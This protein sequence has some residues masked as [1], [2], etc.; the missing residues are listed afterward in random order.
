MSGVGPQLPTVLESTLARWLLGLDG[1]TNGLPAGTTGVSLV[2]EHPM[3]GWAWFLALLCI[4]AF[5]AW[6]YFGLQGSKIVRVVLG[7]FRFVLLVLILIAAT[8]PSLRF[9]REEVERDHVILLIDRSRSIDIAD[10]TAGE[11]RDVVLT[12]AL[13]D[14]KPMFELISQSK[15]ID[16]LGFG[17]TTFPL[18]DGKTDT[19]AFAQPIL[20]PA[21][22]DETRLDLALTQAITR[23]G[24]RPLSAVVILSDGRSAAPVSRET[25]TALR[26]RGIKIFVMPLG[27]KDPIGDASILSAVAPPT[28]FVRDRVPVRVEIDRGAY[29]GTLRAVL[30]DAKSGVALDTQEVRDGV[31][32]IMLDAVSDVPA[33]VQ[34]RVE[35]RGDPPDLVAENNERTLRLSF[36]DQPIRVLFLDGSARWEFRYFKNLLLREDSIEASTMLLSADHDFAQEGN[37]ALARLP[38]TKEE[39]AAY[40]LFVLGDVPS[41]FFAPE[42]LEMIR[43]QVAERGS[44]LLWIG[45][46]RDTPTSWEGTALADLLPFRAPFNLTS[47]RDLRVE[48]TLAARALGLL[49]L[50]PDEDGEGRDGDGWP[51]AF[52]P[53]AS[54]W[55]VLRW[56]QIIPATQ[57]KPT[58]EILAVGIPAF[59][60]TP[61][62]L[63]TPIVLRMRFGAG[64]T[65]YVATDEIWRWRYGQG[66]R[67]HERFWIPIVRMLAREALMSGS[68]NVLLRV[69]PRRATLG[70]RVSVRLELRDQALTDALAGSIPIE[71]RDA[72]GEVVAVIDALRDGSH[73]HAHW[74]AD[75]VG[76]Y[77]AVAADPALDK[78]TAAFEVIRR[79]DE[80]R[81]STPDHQ[82]LV[83]LAEA[84]NGAVLTPTTLRDLAPLLPLRAVTTDA[85]VFERLWDTPLFLILLLLLPTLE[86]TGRRILR[87]A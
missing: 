71:I 60:A 51:N 7:S 30:V 31:T 19:G 25:L 46:E 11:T 42:Q 75:A 10:G 26:D 79:N 16:W 27:S 21:S 47:T 80:L 49:Q 38:Q 8:G 57:L 69:D 53:P 73:A 85:P 40:D 17:G 81:D 68:S 64:E 66:E 48:P 65:I 63:S 9:A 34:W 61:S 39:F 78:A 58:T 24:G 20:S 28:T 55:S 54:P 45:G 59:G 15:E 32:E 23:S 62:T 18:G 33:D 4:V 56:A 3:A 52:G 74:Y 35:L 50:A 76:E 5:V 43:A 83:T 14:A 87:L 6:T 29:K 41:G 77:T 2:F 37:I 22:A 67:L 70:D 82:A 84:T 36:V 1:A 13:E 72:Q 44:G 12:R 86:W